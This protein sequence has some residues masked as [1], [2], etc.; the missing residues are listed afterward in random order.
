MKNKELLENV[1]H[2][3][4]VRPFSIHKTE[5]GADSTNALY[6]HYHP[7]MEFIY[8]DEG[9]MT[10]YVE[11][12]QYN[13]KEGDA[14]FIPPALVHNAVKNTGVPCRHYA[15]V[16][17]EEWLFM[18]NTFERNIYNEII[19][20]Y[21]YECVCMLGR[22]NRADMDTLLLLKKNFCFYADGA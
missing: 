8:L 3:T 16:F 20:P 9:S 12:K 6:V 13:M 7:E 2:F 14:L 17:S 4:K 11:G 15:V 10:F 21:R 1:K 5:I 22:N 18:E 19:Y